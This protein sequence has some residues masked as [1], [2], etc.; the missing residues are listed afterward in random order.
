MKKYLLLLCVLFSMSSL[1]Y[2]NQPTTNE[3]IIV[4]GGSLT[5]II[6][7]LGL[8]D[9]VVGVDQSSTYPEAVKDIPSI[10]YWIQLNIEG[11]LSLTPTILVTWSEAKPASA[12]EQLQQTGTPVLL[13]N[14][15]PATA[16][17]LMI[18][19][20]KIAQTFNIEAKGEELVHTITTRLETIAQQVAQQKERPDVLFLLSISGNPAQVAGKQT[21]ADGIITLAGGHNIAT[22]QNYQIFSAESF[23]AANPDVIILTTQALQSLGGMEQLGKIQ[24][25]NQTKAWQNK[26]I[27]AFDQAILLGI[28]PRIAEAVEGL[29]L[30]FYPTT[31]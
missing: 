2:A 6:Y 14:R 30:A 13:L 18:N 5:E 4:A 22:H 29:Y 11:M 21:V 8:G 20:R 27:V 26:R 31:H 1:V 16:E 23:I 10:G 24:G 9:H 7:Q 17:Q 28:G 3:R 25:I 15:S 12:L 19:I